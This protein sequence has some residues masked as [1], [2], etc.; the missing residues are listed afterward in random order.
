[1]IALWLLTTT[2]THVPTHTAIVM[3]HRAQSCVSVGL[4]WSFGTIVKPRMNVS[5][6]RRQIKTIHRHC[7]CFAAAVIRCGSVG[8]I[9]SFCHAVSRP[10]MKHISI[11]WKWRTRSNTIF[12]YMSYRTGEMMCTTLLFAGDRSEVGAGELQRWVHKSNDSATWVAGAVFS[13]RIGEWV[14]VVYISLL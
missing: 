9:S 10:L 5:V 8:H 4:V 14:C 6:C 3:T 7:N 12:K 2:P 13:C 11:G 1:M